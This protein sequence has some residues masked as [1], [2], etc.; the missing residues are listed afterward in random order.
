MTTYEYASNVAY[1]DDLR[2]LVVEVGVPG[3][4]WMLEVS[5]LPVTGECRAVVD[6]TAWELGGIG[7][8]GWV[9]RHLKPY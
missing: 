3:N 4:A 9:P 5:R 6:H 7:R 1:F 8:E 2:P